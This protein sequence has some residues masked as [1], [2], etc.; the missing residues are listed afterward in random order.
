MPSVS[1]GV[2][3][4]CDCHPI[5]EP[6][7]D[8]CHGSDLIYVERQEIPVSWE[9]WFRWN[10]LEVPREFTVVEMGFKHRWIQE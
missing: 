2:V 9:T 4:L 1:V 8:R 3:T 6:A 7:C 5:E 10:L